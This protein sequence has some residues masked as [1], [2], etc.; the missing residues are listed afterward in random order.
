MICAASHA[1]NW[2]SNSTTIHHIRQT[3]SLDSSISR[4]YRGLGVVSDG[5]PK[6]VCVM[7]T[8]QIPFLRLDQQCKAMQKVF[9]IL[10]QNGKLFITA[11]SSRDS[12]D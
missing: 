5:F 4:V 3:A 10:L 1:K 8:R 6:K 12:N 2:K 7:F 9:I 11:D